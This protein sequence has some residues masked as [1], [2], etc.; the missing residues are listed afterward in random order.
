[1]INPRYVAYAL[2]H[3]RDPDTQLAHDDQAWLGGC[4]TGYILW[5]N[6][7]WAEWNTLNKWPRHAV[8]GPEGPPVVSTVAGR[9]E[10]LDGVER[11]TL[12]QL[13]AK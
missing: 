7:R 13:E 11:H 8:H 1:M 6:D 10:R 4:M 5:I 3:G 12:Y 9:A 2:A